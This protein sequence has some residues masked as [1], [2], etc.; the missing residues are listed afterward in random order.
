MKRWKGAV[1]RVVVLAL[2]GAVVSYAVA[3]GCLLAEV[4][5]GNT[6]MVTGL[7]HSP[8]RPTLAMSRW[9]SPVGRSKW[10]VELAKPHQAHLASLPPPSWMPDPCWAVAPAISSNPVVHWGAAELPFRCCRAAIEDNGGHSSTKRLC[11]LG[12]R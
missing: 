10:I 5:P 4:A 8:D 6:T 3:W 1:R 9:S 12:S 7:H 11:H 2:L